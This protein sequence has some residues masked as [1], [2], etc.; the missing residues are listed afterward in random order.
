VLLRDE[1]T[2]AA[3][4]FHLSRGPL[5][6]ARAV[7]VRNTVGQRA[8]EPT[9]RREERKFCA[10]AFA[11]APGA[12]AAAQE[13]AVWTWAL[14]PNG[15]NQQY[16]VWRLRTLEASFTFVTLYVDDGLLIRYVVRVGLL[17]RLRE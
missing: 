1:S 15:R 13:F 7:Y 9:Q 12:G 2:A 11:A 5:P 10:L 14:G 16:G 17:N 3:A 8:R 4:L 6:A